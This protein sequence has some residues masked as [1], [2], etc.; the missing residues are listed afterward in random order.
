MSLRRRLAEFGFESNDDYEFALR[1]LLEADLP[2]LRV[3][4]VDGSAG[5]RKTAFAHALGQALRYQ[6]VLYHDFSWPEA[7]PRQPAA[8]DDPRPAEPPLRAFERAL[9]EACAYS[10]AAR[11]MLILDQL[12]A[13]PFADHLRLVGFVER[14]EW[15]AGSASVTAH[16]SNF[17]LVLI[18]EEPLYHSL[19]RRSYRVWTNAERAYLDYR[20]EDFGLPRDAQALLDAL[21]GLF[22]ALDASP[23]PSEVGRLLDDL[24]HRVRCE[25]H[26]RQSI[27]GWTE[28]IPRER[29]LAPSIGPLLR[30]VLDALIL[31]LDGERTEL[32][33][34]REPPAAE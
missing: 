34:D 32:A 9:T 21:A 24:L 12:Q 33:A 22:A 25:D 26:L 2:H 23:T 4:H 19:A 8:G 17:L 11:T 31:V 30:Q 27:F 14:G 13:A 6:H 15:S 20:P 1:C 18:S 3:L 10:E 16:R 28:G 5:R 29:L 7:E